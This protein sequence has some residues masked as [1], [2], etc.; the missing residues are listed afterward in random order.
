MVATI[1]AVL[2]A[3]IAVGVL[4]GLVAGQWLA[5]AVLFVA[6]AIVLPHVNINGVN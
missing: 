4:I 1:L 3:L 2:A 5:V 6:L